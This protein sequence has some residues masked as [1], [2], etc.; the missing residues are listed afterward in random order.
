MPFGTVLGKE[1]YEGGGKDGMSYNHSPHKGWRLCGSFY[2]LLMLKHV[3]QGEDE[4]G[5]FFFFF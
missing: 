3:L 1:E 5:N 4:G 2:I